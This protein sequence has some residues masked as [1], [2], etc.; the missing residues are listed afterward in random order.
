MSREE[1]KVLFRAGRGKKSFRVF[2]SDLGLEYV[3]INAHYHT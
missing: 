1:I 3:K 2:A